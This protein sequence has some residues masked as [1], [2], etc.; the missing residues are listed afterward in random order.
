MSGINRWRSVWYGL[1]RLRVRKASI[2]RRSMLFLSLL[3][4]ATS[5]PAAWQL[6]GPFGGDAE[7]IAASQAQH[8][9][10]LAATRSAVVY[11]SLNGGASWEYVHSPRQLS[12]VMHVLKLDPQA[13]GTWYVGLED[14]IASQSGLYRTT[15]RGE[16][17]TQLPGLAGIAIWSLAIWPADPRVMAAGT[18]AG[19]YGSEDAGASWRRISPEDETELRP[20][21]S[22]AFDPTDRKTIYAGTTHLPW[23]TTDGGASWSS[24]H[25]GML[26][27]SD[28]F[29]MSVDPN[30][31]DSVFASACSGVYRSNNRGGLWTRLPT[32]PGAFRVYLVAQDP[33]HPEVLFAATT[34]GLVRSL[35]RG[36]TWTKVSSK[37]VK[38]VAFDPDGSRVYAASLTTGILISTDGGQSFR[39]MN[40]GFADHNLTA[41]TGA[42]GILYVSSIYEGETGGIFRSNNYGSS[43]TL[44]AGATALNGVNLRF[45]TAAPGHADHLF[46]VPFRGLL[47][48]TDGGRTWTRSAG[49]GDG[50]ILALGVLPPGGTEL[51]AGTASGLFRSSDAGASWKPVVIDKNSV[52]PRIDWIQLSGQSVA[53]LGTGRSAYFSE[54]GGRSWALCAPP[55]PD[56]Q[57][58]G[59]A[60]TLKP[61][62]SAVTATSH[63][64]FRTDD[65]CRSWTPAETGTSGTASMVLSHPTRPD[66][67]IAVQNGQVVYSADAGLRWLPLGD[68]APGASYPSAIVVLPDDPERMFVLLPRRGVFRTGP[69]GPERAGDFIGAAATRPQ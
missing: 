14:R 59:L 66:Q 16:T 9:F 36:S 26:D 60:G 3:G 33:R 64:L 68:G 7:F 56:V 34:A 69:I 35:N 17:W 8:D 50:A 57:W 12:A 62:R 39:D 25:E 51:L 22:L 29:S 47:R 54:D 55:V 2:A 41:M 42:E 43:W 63:G 27:D 21:V 28:V 53:A 4:L 48:S 20:V 65:G 23:R 61:E 38:S 30:H 32:P 19:V 31:P 58:Y 1:V 10:L 6:T 67:F 11:Q 5:L 13:A 24:I 52:S 44:V 18:A 15:D 45:V 37:V 40:W 49:P 46:A